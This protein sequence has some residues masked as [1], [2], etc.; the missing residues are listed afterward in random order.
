M[1]GGDSEA[2]YAHYALHRLKIR[3]GLLAGKS[4]NEPIDRK[5]RAFIY[6]SIGIHVEKE[7]RATNKIKK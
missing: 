6:G 4:P 5:E 1:K 2:N 7:Y 3:P